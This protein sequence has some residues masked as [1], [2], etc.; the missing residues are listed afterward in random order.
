MHPDG[1]EGLAG[2]AAWPSRPPRVGRT[3]HEPEQ[4]PNADNDTVVL[5]KTRSCFYST[6]TAPPNPSLHT[7]V[8]RRWIYTRD[9]AVDPVTALALS[10]AAD[11]T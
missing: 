4:E 5:A 2:M 1:G 11:I 10:H 3:R 9:T 6:E 7:R 8:Q